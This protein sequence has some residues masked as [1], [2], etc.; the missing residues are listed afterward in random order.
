MFDAPQNLFRLFGIG[1]ALIGCG[2]LVGAFLSYRSTTEFLSTAVPGTGEV[3]GYD[4]RTD[5]E[6]SIA[7]YPVITFSP[8]GDSEIEFTSSTGGSDRPYAIG[9]SVPLRY[10]PKLPFNA[11]IDT[12]TDIWLVTGVLG[13]LGAVFML[14]GGGLFWFLGMGGAFSKVAFSASR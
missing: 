2:L 12:P 5:S 7:Y 6:G 8:N 4:R 10:D 1:F 9:A 11:T 3:I 14:V 13:G